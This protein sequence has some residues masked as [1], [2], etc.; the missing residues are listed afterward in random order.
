MSAG[1]EYL[2]CYVKDPALRNQYNLLFEILNRQV[3]ALSKLLKV[4]AQKQGFLKKQGHVVKNWKKRFFLLTAGV[5]TYYENNG[6]DGSGQAETPKGSLKLSTCSV[7][8]VLNDEY[9]KPIAITEQMFQVV[10]E[11]G[12]GGAT[13]SKLVMKADSED[14]KKEWLEAI[15]KHIDYARNYLE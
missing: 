14:D 9:N 13:V 4:P 8:V 12:G 7:S 15:R 1:G 2:Y 11:G 5:L 3:S 6:Q 10:D